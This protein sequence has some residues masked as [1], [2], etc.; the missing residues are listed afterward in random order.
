MDISVVIVCFKGWTHLRNCLD[1]LREAK[2]NSV[3]FE[4]IVADN[5]SGDGM[6]EQFKT[7][8]PD[9]IFVENKVNGGFAYGCNRGAEKA[10]GEFLLFL[11][12]DTVVGKNSLSGLLGAARQYPDVHIMSCRQT[13][14]KGKESSAWGHFLRPGLLTGTGRMLAS[15]F[16][17]LNEPAPNRENIFFPDWVSGSVMLVQ[18][19][20]FKSLGG[21]DEDYWMYFEDM[22]IC[23]RVAKS[24]GGI[25]V[26]RNTE[27]LHCHGGSSRI[28]RYTSSITKSE[29]LVSKHIFIQ[30]HLSGLTASIIHTWLAFINIVSLT[31]KSIAGLLFFFIPK[32]SVA[33]FIL[34]HLLRYYASVLVDGRW[35]SRRSVRYRS[36]TTK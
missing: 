22:D 29:V 26:T 21:F 24:G 7:D 30:K 19:E 2:S 16:G 23:K 17:L 27:I 31:L 35:I 28:N 10:S 1:S 36:E 9:Y 6:L 32:L 3:S 14:L 20:I 34:Q 15:L 4:V 13:D 25:A 18:S 12:P 5:N 8:Y 11:N 33:P